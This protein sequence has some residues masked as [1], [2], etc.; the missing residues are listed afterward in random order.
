[1]SV[2]SQ[3]LL[4]QISPYHAVPV[5]QVVPPSVMIAAASTWSAS[6]P[7]SRR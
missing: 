4:N 6:P 3:S 2:I 1:M 5:V 7:K